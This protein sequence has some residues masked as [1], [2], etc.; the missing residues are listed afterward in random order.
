MREYV[1]F[2]EYLLSDGRFGEMWLKFVDKD[3]LGNNLLH[4][5]VELHNTDFTK[6]VLAKNDAYGADLLRQRNGAGLTPSELLEKEIEKARNGI[7]PEKT[8]KQ[9][10]LLAILKRLMPEESNC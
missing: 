8:T 1:Q 7:N 4:A 5:C 9:L 3:V 6:V 2:V 10:N